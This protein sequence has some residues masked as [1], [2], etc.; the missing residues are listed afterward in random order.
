ME[1]IIV[2]CCC[3]NSTVA[4]CHDTSGLWRV[5]NRPARQRPSTQC[6]RDDHSVN[7]YCWRQRILW[8]LM[9]QMDTF[10]QVS[11]KIRIRR[12]RIPVILGIRPDPDTNRIHQMHRISG[13][14]RIWI[15]CIPI[16]ICRAQTITGS[17]LRCTYTKDVVCVAYITCLFAGNA[18]SMI[19]F[20]PVNNES[21][22]AAAFLL[23]CLAVFDNIMLLLYYLLTGIPYTCRYYDSCQ[24]YMEVT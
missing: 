5:P 22:T 1:H 4:V 12:I 10:K 17:Y 14:I 18:V 7:S 3:H 19:V 23:M 11:V 20:W 15:R 2:T 9:L 6:M 21:P 8:C 16:I 24:Y 13:R